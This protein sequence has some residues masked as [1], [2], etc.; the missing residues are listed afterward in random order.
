MNPLAV[1][2]I[3]TA[4]SMGANKVAQ[5]KVDQQRNAA[6]AEEK[7]LREESE[8]KKFANTQ[9]TMELFADAAGDEGRRARELEAEYSS[10]GDAAP[11]MTA[12][13]MPRGVEAPAG[14]TYNVLGGD[15]GEYAAE[16]DRFVAGQR[17]AMSQLDAFR[18]VM[19]TNSLSAQRLAGEIDRENT[20]LRNWSNY[21]LPAQ[22]EAAAGAGKKWNTIADVAQLVAT[23]YGMKGLAKPPAEA[24]VE[25]AGA[26]ASGVG[27]GAAGAAGQAGR[28]ASTVA[29][30]T[31]A[32]T[33]VPTGGFGKAM[34][35]RTAPGAFGLM[36]NE[37]LSAETLAL[38][39][40]RRL[41]PL[42]KL[43]LGLK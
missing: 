30:N 29:A 42:D 35:G 5:K 24:G 38:L 41:S 13:P 25:A 39:Q 26:A 43:R 9:T 14:A 1:Y 11:D 3:M 36:G 37:G 34:F 16:T 21:V 31:A 18:D 33:N 17:R 20:N 4:L 28:S 22:L 7:R 12:A 10:A 6:L 19:G 32:S 40:G 8:K 15:G 23:I 2:A 27:S